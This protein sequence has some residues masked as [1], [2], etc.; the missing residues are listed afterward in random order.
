[1]TKFIKL[2]MVVCTIIALTAFQSIAQNK[3]GYIDF[4]ALLVEM[5]EYKKA[6]TDMEAFGK[7]FQD[8]L[9]KMSSELERKYD[10]YQK[11]EAKM[12]E[13]IR[14]LKQKELRDMQMRMQEF[15]ETAQ[16]KIRDKE[17]ELL[18][19]IV[20]R[21]KKGI[22][23]V[24]KD[25]GYSYIFDSSPGSPLLHKPDGDDVMKQVM[26]KLGITDTPAP[27]GTPKK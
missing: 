9:R 10:E 25:G 16:D 24:A 19:P 27:A 14:E 17:Q 8:E 4:Q 6:N 22:S 5:P 26:K 13:P 23:D 2:S 7:Q 11:G 3:F 20:E 12:S 15:Q 18:K 21:A 1:M